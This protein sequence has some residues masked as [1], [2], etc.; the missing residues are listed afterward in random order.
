MS[1]YLLAIALSLHSVKPRQLFEGMAIGIQ[2]DDSKIAALGLSVMFHKLPEAFALGVNLNK[3][4]EARTRVVV[5]IFTLSTPIGILI[6]MLIEGVFPSVEG[7][8]L[9]L[10]AGTFLYI[11]ACEI[12]VEEFSV[13][14]HKYSKFACFTGGLALIASLISV[15]HA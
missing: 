6:S 7:I 15:L 11:A 14:K 5:L 1:A 8:V 4:P 9:A 3:H 2:S 13:S 12:V 10:S